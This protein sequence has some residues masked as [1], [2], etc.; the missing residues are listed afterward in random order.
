MALA[1]GVTD[2][3]MFEG[4]ELLRTLIQNIVSVN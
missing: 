4:V 1:P 2:R 3:E